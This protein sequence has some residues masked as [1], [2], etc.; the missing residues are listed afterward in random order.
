MIIS[1][2]GVASGVGIGGTPE[3]I[4]LRLSRPMRVDC[5][6][7]VNFSAISRIKLAI[8]AI[9]TDDG[10]LLKKSDMEELYEAIQ[11][12]G[13]WIIGTDEE[14]IAYFEGTTAGDNL[15]LTLHGHPIDSDESPVAVKTLA[16]P[17]WVL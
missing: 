16:R 6:E 5:V 17:W 8:G 3:S 4:R 9:G 2:K 1:I 7:G 15:I 14:I 13:N 11:A 10:V 12:N